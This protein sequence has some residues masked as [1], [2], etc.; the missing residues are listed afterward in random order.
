MRNPDIVRRLTLQCFSAQENNMRSKF[1]ALVGA[2]TM[3][4]TG[5][6]FGAEDGF[7]RNSAVRFGIAGGRI[8]LDAHDVD[9][10]G[11]TTDWEL[12]VGFEFNRHLA[13]EAGYII[14]GKAKDDV[15]GVVIEDDTNAA[16]AS[17]IGSLPLND[18]VTA[19]AR[20]GL[21]HWKSDREARLEGQVLDTEAVD[22]T[23]P[24]YGAGLAALIDD[25]LVRLEYRIADLDDRDF[26]YVSLAI[27]WRF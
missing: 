22:G 4:L 2:T 6:A 27:A 8:V 14:G 16:Y 3:L 5:P 20:G 11:R 25:A 23:D 7:L 24:F 19:Y 12:F 26:G 21:L 1:I 17:V 13:I 15:D 18:V 9:L 10:T